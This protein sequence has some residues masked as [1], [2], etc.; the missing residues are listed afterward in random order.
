MGPGS[1]ARMAGSWP[2][3]V[4]SGIVVSEESDVVVAVPCVQKQR[5]T[6]GKTVFPC[7]GEL[8]VV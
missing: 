1:M 7:F 6:R 8:K 5:E 2:S 4:I 3:K